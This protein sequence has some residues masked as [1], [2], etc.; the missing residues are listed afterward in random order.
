MFPKQ[1]N[2]RR[3]PRRQWGN[4]FDA[5][6]PGGRKPHRGHESSR[7]GM[8]GL[9]GCTPGVG[10]C[11][12]VCVC[13]CVCARVRAGVSGIETFESCTGFTLEGPGT[14]EIAFP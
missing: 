7:V 8:V 4:P 5:C 9:M 6:S 1:V 3:I 13:V 11:V 12:C 14:C 2:V 10:E